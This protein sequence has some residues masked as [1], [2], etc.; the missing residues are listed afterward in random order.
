MNVNYNYYCRYNPYHTADMIAAIVMY[1][2][3][4]T[5]QFLAEGPWA[6]SLASVRFSVEKDDLYEYT[7]FVG[8]ALRECTNIDESRQ[9]KKGLNATRD[10]NVRHLSLSVGG[11]EA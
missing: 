3:R 7:L 6:S 2:S 9:A 4:S 8:S 10:K 11:R 5:A 1:S